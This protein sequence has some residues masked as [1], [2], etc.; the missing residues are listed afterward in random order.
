MNGR[1]DTHC[2]ANS[3]YRILLAWVGNGG[4]IAGGLWLIMGVSGVLWIVLSVL[5][6]GTCGLLERRSRYFFLLS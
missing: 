5:E 4:M 6:Y 1:S 3:C 2:F